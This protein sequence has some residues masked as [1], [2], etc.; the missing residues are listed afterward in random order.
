MAKR[1]ETSKL[2][3]K[4]NKKVK[5]EKS[6]NFYIYGIFQDGQCLYIGQ[7]TNF[8]RRKEEH[9]KELM[10]NK[11]ENKSLQKYYN[12]KPQIEVKQLLEIPTTNTLIIFFIEGLMNSIFKP[13]ANKIV[14]MQGR[15]RIV[16]QRVDENLANLLVKTV[17]EY[18]GGKF[19]L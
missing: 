2:K 8:E 7:T 12:K 4:L 1:S 14:M 19:S 16:L 18:Y 3:S 10:Y 5:I 6:N 17:V 15:S 9:I 11:H 13:K